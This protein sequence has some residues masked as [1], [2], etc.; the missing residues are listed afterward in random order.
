M[1]RSRGLSDEGTTV[2]LTQGLAYKDT[3]L[4]R[5]RV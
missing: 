5:V 2:M 1:E 4:Y 3:A